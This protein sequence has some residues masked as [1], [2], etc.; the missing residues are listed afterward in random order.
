MKKFLCALLAVAVAGTVALGGCR[1][2]SGTD[3]RDGQDLNIYDIYEATNAEREAAGLE[4]LSFL[5]FLREYFNY[6]YEYTDAENLQAIINRSLMSSVSVLSGFN[7]SQGISSVTQ[8]YAGSGVFVDVDKEAGD[9]YVLTNYHVVYDSSSMHGFADDIQL[10][11]YGMED[12][13]GIISRY[14]I[15]GKL[16]GASATY[17]LALIKVENSKV[18]RE[19]DAM[20][21][22]FAQSEEV[23]AGQQVYIVGNPEGMGMSVTTGVVSKES[24][25]ITVNLSNTGE[26]Y[27]DYRVIR[28][29]AAVNGGNSGGGMFDTSGRLI[30]LINSKLTSTEDTGEYIEAMAN[31]LAGSY[32][33]RV[34]GLMRDGYVAN[35]KSLGLRRAVSPVRFTY[36]SSAYFDNEENVAKIVDKVVVAISSP[37]GK[38]RVGDVMENI[39]ILRGDAVIEDVP[40]TRVFNVEDVLLSAREGDKVV[41]TVL[42][43]GEHIEITTD[44]TFENCA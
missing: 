24:E 7:Y 13:D 22:R 39:K 44:P 25:F 18:I 3:G 19:S 26:D 34:A 30:G 38:L 5:D 23:Y 17:D 11:L 2:G 27:Y 41:Y 16:V 36:T 28:T 12:F 43:D 35:S 21:V 15:D 1:L 8:Y 6:S 14:S 42:R 33:R 37:L 20:A 40:I 32:V 31:A 29:D 9:A 10:F 4:L